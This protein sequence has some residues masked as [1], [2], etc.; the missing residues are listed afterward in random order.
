MDVVKPYPARD[1]ERL[2]EGWGIMA[3]DVMAGVYANLLVRVVA[4]VWPLW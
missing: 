4:L 3:D 2:P 1:L